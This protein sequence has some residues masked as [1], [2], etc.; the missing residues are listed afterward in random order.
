M[1]TRKTSLRSK[2]ILMFLLSTSVT[3]TL[4]ITGSL[5]GLSTYNGVE[6]QIDM[7][8]RMEPIKQPSNHQV[9]QVTIKDNVLQRK[10]LSRQNFETKLD[11]SSR[12]LDTSI[13]T[14]TKSKYD[15][16]PLTFTIHDAAQQ[17]GDVLAFNKF[18][19]MY[20]LEFEPGKASPESE[21]TFISPQEFY[22]IEVSKKWKNNGIMN[23]PI[24]D[25]HLLRRI[26][27]GESPND[28]LTIN[29]WSEWHGTAYYTPKNK[30]LA[31]KDL[32]IIAAA[33]IS[34]T[35]SC[36]QQDFSPGD[37]MSKIQGPKKKQLSASNT[38]FEKEDSIILGDFLRT[39][40][41]AKSLPRFDNKW[42]YGDLH[43]HSQGT[44][45]EGESGTSYRSALAAMKA[46][47]LDYAFATDHASDSVQFTALQDIHITEFDT[48]W[49]VS[50]WIV[51]KFVEGIGLPLLLKKEAY[52][53]MSSER[54]AH[55]K[56]WLQGDGGANDEVSQRP[57]SNRVPQIF[58]GGEVD[59]IPEIS[60]QD[61]E[62]KYY[63]YGAGLIYR[64]RDACFA[65]P[66]IIIEKTDF[67]EQCYND[68]FLEDPKGED[69][70]VLLRDVQGPFTDFYARQHL[71]Y[72]PRKQV[73]NTFIS[74]E[75][76]ELGG[77]TRS[78]KAEVTSDSGTPNGVLDEL[79]ITENSGYLFLAHPAS[80]ATGNGVGR[81]AGPDIF[82]YSKAQL[83]VAF[84]SKHV[85]GLQLWN[86]NARFH[87]DNSEQN[88]PFMHDTQT[89]NAETQEIV[90][91]FSAFIDKQS[92]IPDTFTQWQNLDWS[93]Q[94]QDDH[95]MRSS[96][97]NGTAMWD[98]VNLW[99]IT[100]EK[101]ADIDFLQ[102]GEPRKFFMAGGSDA[103][104]DM[105]YR[106]EG[107][108]ATGW[109]N[110]NDTAIGTPRNLT[111]VGSDRNSQ[112][113][114]QPTVGQNQ[115]LDGLISGRFSVTDGPAFRIA[116]D[117]NSNGIIDDQDIHM[118]ED[119][120]LS[121]AQ[122]IRTSRFEAVARPTTSKFNLIVEWKSTPEW[123]PV[124]NIKLLVGVQEGSREGLVYKHRSSDICG[125]NNLLKDAN[126]REYCPTVFNTYVKDPGSNLSL[127]VP[128]SQGM[129][130]RKVIEL[131]AYDYKLF[132][133][134]CDRISRAARAIRPQD[135]DIFDT[136]LVLDP[137]F[138]SANIHCSAK[139][140]A[141]PQ[142]L[143][144]R[145]IA[146]T[147]DNTNPPVTEVAL[148]NPT[149]A[150]TTTFQTLS[151]YS[152]SNPVWIRDIPKQLVRN[153]TSVLHIK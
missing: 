131:D 14:P 64:W 1:K 119:A 112:S 127:V 74:S 97:L 5:G 147:I 57:G 62:N 82:P 23:G 29:D 109:N 66:S 99:G 102:S 106:R 153:V 152:Y 6:W 78:L 15:P 91:S 86:E 60:S 77:A 120:T 85:L 123:G 24:A 18:C 28:V 58:L 108:P 8:W 121:E 63:E 98:M 124:K 100:P 95:A 41:A 56:Q 88:F 146:T 110:T 136:D 40:Y 22:E 2:T 126:G 116:L 38:I 11:D 81:I 26:W 142:R 52:R 144:V 145:A 3:S 44:D 75:T 45:N 54:N 96:L 33:R 84:N 65:V 71:L 42:V 30:S 10:T 129:Q 34:R 128:N 125:N 87:S 21:L 35:N 94:K 12:F 68:G 138:P 111:F 4:A 107:S 114:G 93:W 27:M 72:L 139:N 133:K 150:D 48:G 61:N 73:E 117:T 113:S 140:I 51:N 16:I 122:G 137:S 13:K 25:S 118:G 130:G 53:D 135:N 80:A 132:N 79:D 67:A 76:S 19:G 101:V 115:I 49:I 92:Y 50:D 70:R 43:Y 9:D 46:L 17:S 141:N 69:G 104:G 59:I 134:V 105:N 55:L 31:G 90:D 36:S 89:L 20:I 149:T 39:H 7:P 83:A 37:I 32:R 151:R 103:H 148:E 47:A 143:F